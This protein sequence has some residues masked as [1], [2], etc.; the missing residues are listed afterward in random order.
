MTDIQVAYF[1][2]RITFTD[3]SFVKILL[4]SNGSNHEIEPQLKI[5]YRM[6]DVQYDCDLFCIFIT[7]SSRMKDGICNSLATT[8]KRVSPFAE[9]GI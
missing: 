5:L 3:P 1:G 8:T 2:I 4:E 6:N 9:W 7:T